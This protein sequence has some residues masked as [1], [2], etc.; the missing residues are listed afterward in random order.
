MPF[1]SAS[2]ACSLKLHMTLLTAGPMRARVMVHPKPV[3]MPKAACFERHS[4]WP[5][6]SKQAKKRSGTKAKICRV[7]DLSTQRARGQPGGFTVSAARSKTPRHI[8]TTPTPCGKASSGNPRGTFLQL[9]G[10]GSHRFVGGE[11]CAMRTVLLRHLR[12][13]SYLDDHLICFFLLDNFSSRFPI[14]HDEFR[15]NSRT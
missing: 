12:T 7:M 15:K 1:W 14:L 3:M 10:D 9:L 2:A 6:A 8:F 13:G 11:P 4:H 5:P